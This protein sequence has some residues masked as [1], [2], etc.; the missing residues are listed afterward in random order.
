MQ[1]PW[2]ADPIVNPSSAPPSGPIYGL[3]RQPPMQT[4]EQATGQ[5]LQN[6]HTDQQIASQP[7]VNENT[8]VN[9]EQGKASI[10]NQRFTQNQGLRQ[11]FANL[12]LVKNYNTISQKTA[13]ALGAPDTPQGDLA[14]LYGFATVMDPNSVVRESEQEMAQRTASTIAQLK[15]KFN[16]VTDGAR[17]PAGVRDG[18]LEEMR[19]NTLTVNGFYNQQRHYYSD[20][21]K[22]NGFDPQE[23]VGPHPTEVSMPVEAN[24]IREH[25]GTPKVNGV[26]TD[27]HGHP[28]Q[29]QDA[30]TRSV[31]QFGD[32]RGD[33]PLPPH[34]D[35]FRNGLYNAM[36]QRKINSPADMRAWVD[37]FN[38]QN[39]TLYQPAYDSK[40]TM[41]A[42][43]EARAG[44]SFDVQLP[45]YTPDIK[46]MR[47]GSGIGEKVDAG[48]RGAAD[49]LSMSAADK[50]AAVGDTLTRGGTTFDEN[51][52]RQYA[53]SD[54]DTE[55]HFPSRVTGQ[56]LGG[57]AL[58]M[59]E[60][61]TMPQIVGKSAALGATY[62][63]VSSRSLA[64]VPQNALLGGAAGGATGAVF[65]GVPRAIGALR[66]SKDVPPLV[67]PATGELNQP[68]DAMRP[69]QRMQ[70]M[71][72]QG[73]N[74]ITP[75][76]AG[77]RSARV[78]EQGFNNVPGS[79]GVMEDV[80][81]AASKELRGAMQNTAQQFGTSKTLSEGGSELQRG[82]QERIDRGKAV[83][84]KAYDAIP[85]SPD[86]P[87]STG[88]TVATLRELTGRLQSN[89]D[90]AAAVKD[91]KLAQYLN[92]FE[93]GKLSW[94]DLKQFRT[95]IGEKI[96]DMRFGES[97]STSDLR[98]LYA[99]L[100]ED[101]RNTAASMGPKAVRAFERAN[102]LNRQNEQMIDG[103]LTRILGKDGQ[104]SPEKAAAAVQAMTQGGKATGDLKTL[105]QIRSATIKSGAWDEIAATLIHLGGQP[106]KSEGRAFSPQTFVQ[107]YADMSE[108]ARRMLFKPELRKS[109]D[110]FVATNQQLSRVKGLTN[111]SNTTPTMIGSG[112]VAAGGVAAVTHPPAL[113]ALVGGA[114]TN[115]VMAKVWTSPKFVQW[116]TG[117]SRAVASGNENAVKS[118]IGR[119]SKLAITNPELRE[120]IQRLLKSIANDNAPN[121]GQIAASPDQGPQN[122]AQPQ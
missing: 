55:N 109:L 95:L 103:A 8:R 67:D 117:Y 38:Q 99:G 39:G 108:P 100:S 111:A 73:L 47:G 78:I 44:R 90:L 74:T 62:G 114:L 58:P 27:D 32:E 63:G 60:M 22:R 19:A 23:I 1:N 25:G 18:L 46:D 10:Q 31:G 21:A 13:A 83:I 6:V 20:L 87:A 89:P 121:A 101:M 119:L 17:L 98:A 102:T 77:G 88:S 79:A 91:P 16:M 50:L 12:P 120:P 66:G 24:Y 65:G 80:N 107:W 84:G 48:I 42:I 75:G 112:L 59:G 115:T 14:I 41:Q 4:P 34:A 49:M 56:V 45:R 3:P 5:H 105:A 28:I 61:T 122:Q 2:D 26:P 51:L 33:A 52:A 81:S 57:L 97:S 116:A 11:E 70:M 68:M 40:S 37:R 7:L 36:R 72:D 92:A 35:D 29:T 93:G 15:Q 64:D 85:I 104:M 118:Q 54:Y 71:S 53:I 9:I 30:P 76:M 94:Q 110:N 106:S 43:R 82:A 96:G 113:L 86:A 69:A